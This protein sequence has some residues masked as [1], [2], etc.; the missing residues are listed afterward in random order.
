MRKGERLCHIMNRKFF[1]FCVACIAVF[2]SRFCW[3]QSDMTETEMKTALNQCYI[4]EF[5]DQKIYG[6]YKQGDR[7]AIKY[8]VQYS[9]IGRPEAYMAM[10]KSD[11]TL[12]I[13]SCEPEDV[14]ISAT[15]VEYKY[16]DG[17]PAEFLAAKTL[18]LHCPDG[19]VARA[20]LKGLHHFTDIPEMTGKRKTDEEKEMCEE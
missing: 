7:V 3:A 15:N 10:S 6:I 1:I 12:N 11:V 5:I 14:R 20:A 17:H 13:L 19:L 16:G 8:L 9:D 2:G 18:F 4:D